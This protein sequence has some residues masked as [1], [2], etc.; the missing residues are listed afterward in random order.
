MM[1]T[2]HAE[3]ARARTDSQLETAVE[4]DRLTLLDRASLIL[5]P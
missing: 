2:D 5:L 4:D 1:A 3:V